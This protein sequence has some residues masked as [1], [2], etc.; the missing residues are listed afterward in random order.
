MAGHG[1]RVVRGELRV[2]GVGRGQQLARAGQVGHVGV[3]LARVDRVAF[4]AIDLRALDLAVPV[5]ALDQPH[6]QAVA[7][8]ARQVDQVVDHERAAL[9]VGLDHKADAVPALP[10]R[11]QSTASPAGRATAPAGRPLRRRCSGRC[12]TGAPARPAQQARVQLVHHAVALRAAVAR[13][14]GRELDRDARPFM[15]AAPVGRL[16]DGVDRLLV[17]RQVALGVVCSVSA[18]SPSMS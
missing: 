7:A 17:G 1:V 12:R 2:D 11:A 10:V 16:A 4:Q 18:A 13:V 9:L 5:R 15:D 3:H 14:Q 6:H 8:A